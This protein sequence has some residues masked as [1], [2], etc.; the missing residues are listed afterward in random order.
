[1]YFTAVS[2]LLLDLNIKNAK[3]I[4]IIKQQQEHDHPTPA[5]HIDVEQSSAINIY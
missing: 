4:T 1:M 5:A 3:I 2:S